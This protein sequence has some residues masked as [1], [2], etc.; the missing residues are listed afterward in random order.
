[1]TVRPFDLKNG[2][3]LVID[4][5]QHVGSLRILNNKDDQHLFTESGRKIWI[6]QSVTGKFNMGAMPSDKP[7]ELPPGRYELK[8]GNPRA[9]V[10][11]FEIKTGDETVIDFGG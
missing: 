8:S 2:E 6:D 10:E 3:S 5:Q 11:P 1:M 7:V 4:F 9:A